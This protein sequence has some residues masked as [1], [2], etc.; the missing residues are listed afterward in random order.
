MNIDAD[1]VVVGSGVAGAITACRLAE[2]GVKNIVILEAG[3]RIDRAET[4]IKFRQSA[5]L[6]SSDGY[7]SPDWAPRPEWAKYN[8]SG[9]APY[10]EQAGPAKLLQSEYLRVVGGTTWHWGGVTPRFL[11]VDFRMRTAYGVGLDWPLNYD[12]MEPFYTEAEQEIGI[13]GQ[14]DAIDAY[15]SKSYPLPPVPLSYCDRVIRDGLLG[16]GI[17]LT[18][19]PCARATRPYAGRGQ[20]MGF[21]TCS[22]ICPSGA[23]Y[24]AIYHV[25][26]AEKLGVRV[27]ENTRVDRLVA[28][29]RITT[30]E[31]R[32]PDGSLIRVRGKIIVL[33]ANAMETPRLLLMSA[34]EHHPAG[35]ANRSGQVGRNYMEHPSING[36]LRMPKP[37]YAGRGPSTISGSTRGRD[38]AFRA[39]RPGWILSVENKIRF[40]EITGELLAS[41]A[42]PPALDAA[43]KDRAEREIELDIGMEQ[44][45]DP[46]NGI[47]LDWSRRDRAGQPTIRHYYSF[48]DYEQAGFSHAREML[49][50]IAKTLGADLLWTS[51]P[52]TQHHIIGMTRMGED[53]K[54][55]V[56]DSFGRSHDH[57]NL[58]IASSSLFP[59]GGTAN[60]TLTIAALAL[61]M[62]GEIVR[63]LGAGEHG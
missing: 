13:A 33:A 52:A 11:P 42:E 39:E 57:R 54:T 9:G 58:F 31:A 56:T 5:F 22:P 8:A 14:P 17:E 27:R 38:G 30:I 45:P 28:Q 23:H 53:P 2:K 20:C 4:V 18:P 51:D 10:I 29:G 3:P 41:G 59:T 48:T 25:E 62:A 35:I 1:V 61:R 32:K 40:H 50:R 21:G 7:P 55:S 15:R 26:K 46:T 19:R 43:I 47:S 63:Q 60:P 34:G 16:D 24:S 44:L 49:A 12:E 6:D 37:V 36:R